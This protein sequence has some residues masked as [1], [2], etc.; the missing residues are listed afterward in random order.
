MTAKTKPLL[1]FDKQYKDALADAK[2][3]SDAFVSPEMQYRAAMEHAA[4]FKIGDRVRLRLRGT[5]GVI[6]GLPRTHEQGSVGLTHGLCNVR[7]RSGEFSIPLSEVELVEEEVN[8]VNCKRG[9][10][11]E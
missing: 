9:N 6:T 10:Q 11:D 2:R 3:R 4:R 5:E 8:A 7:T 1:D